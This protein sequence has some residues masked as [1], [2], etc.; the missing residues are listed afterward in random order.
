MV[1]EVVKA[2][3]DILD[4]LKGIFGTMFLLLVIVIGFIVMVTA[5][6]WYIG[7]MMIVLAAGT[8]AMVTGLFRFSGGGKKKKKQRGAYDGIYINNQGYVGSD[9]FANGS[10]MDVYNDILFRLQINESVVT[11]LDEFLK[12]FNDNFD[13]IK[14]NYNAL[15]ETGKTDLKDCLLKIPNGE[16]LIN[17][18]TT[19]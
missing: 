10:L 8:A 14:Q 12:I 15:T 17:R 19:S 18:L 3:P 13:T 2:A 16:E 11:S 5:E 7:L 9:E 1:G 6:K 4:S